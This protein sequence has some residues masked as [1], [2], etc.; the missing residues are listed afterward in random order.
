MFLR[1][2]LLADL[3]LLRFAVELLKRRLLLCFVIHNS[4]ALIADLWRCVLSGQSVFFLI[5]LLCFFCFNSLLFEFFGEVALDKVVDLDS[6]CIIR[7]LFGG[8]LI[9]RLASIAVAVRRQVLLRHEQ[10]RDGASLGHL[11]RFL[12]DCGLSSQEF[13]LVGPD[14]ILL[15]LSHSNHAIIV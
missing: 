6:L 8:V 10:V 12:V 1:Q 3:K 11:P 4:D 15:F 13:T 2:L 14:Y 7:R 9:R 5:A